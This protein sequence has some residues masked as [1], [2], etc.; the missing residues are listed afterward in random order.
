MMVDNQYDSALKNCVGSESK[1]TECDSVARDF[2][3]KI[4]SL[5][6]KF[7]IIS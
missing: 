5:Y 4:R 7:Y 3:D 1:K 6:K 2:E